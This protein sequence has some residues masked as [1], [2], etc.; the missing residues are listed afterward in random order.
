V[1]S[2]GEVLAPRPPDLRLAAAQAEL[3]RLR[4]MVAELRQDRDARRVQAERLA[5]KFTS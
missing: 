4:E 3:R 5:G 2:V 1:A